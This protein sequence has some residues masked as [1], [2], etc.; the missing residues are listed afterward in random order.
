MF[1]PLAAMQALHAIR[2][3]KTERAAEAQAYAA[4]VAAGRSEVE[5]RA[6]VREARLQRASFLTEPPRECHCS[7]PQPEDHT[8]EYI[9]AFLLGGLL[10]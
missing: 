7:T 1:G 5:A 8:A 6:F 3:M 9:G 10:F 4:C 2:M